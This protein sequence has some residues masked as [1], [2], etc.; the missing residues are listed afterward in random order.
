LIALD[1]FQVFVRVVT[2]AIQRG[3]QNKAVQRLLL[4]DLTVLLNKECQ[5]N[6]TQMEPSLQR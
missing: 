2:Q 4:Q 3:V 5:G 6:R 1:E